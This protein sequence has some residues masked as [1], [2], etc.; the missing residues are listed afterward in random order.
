MSKHFRV[1]VVG[2]GYVATH[3]LRALRDLPFV[4]TVGIAD[5]DE[6]RARELASKFGVTGVYRDLSHMRE[7]LPDVIHVLTPP[8]SH[9]TLALEALAMGCHVLVEK[10]MAESEEECAERIARA[11]EAGRI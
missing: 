1:G 10:P 11:A 7:A 4:E 3:H 2:A 9:K 5:L 8:A 6:T